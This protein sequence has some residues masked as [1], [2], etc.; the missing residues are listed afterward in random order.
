MLLLTAAL[1]QP[2]QLFLNDPRTHDTPADRCVDTHCR[3]LLHLIQGARF[4]IDFAVYGFRDQSEVIDALLA[5]RE[6][7]VAVRG[8]V[9][10][11]LEGVNYYASTAEVMERLPNI[12]TDHASDVRTARASRRFSSRTPWCDRPVAIR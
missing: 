12:H 2:V 4:S 5:A 10:V 1:A 7:G 8:V 3:A 11:D 9:D 6:R